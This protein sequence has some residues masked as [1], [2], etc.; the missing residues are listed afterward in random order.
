MSISADS[1]L[2]LLIELWGVAEIEKHI[3]KPS[4]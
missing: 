1:R 3:D 2:M 4:G